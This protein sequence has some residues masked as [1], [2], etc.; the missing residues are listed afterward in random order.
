MLPDC[1]DVP[2]SALQALVDTVVP[3]APPVTGRNVLV[4]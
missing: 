4:G 1:G 3:L 2:V